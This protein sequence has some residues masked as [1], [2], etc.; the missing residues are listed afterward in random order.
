VFERSLP[1]V[2]PSAALSIKE[3]LDL[4]YHVGY[5]RL[6]PVTDMYLSRMHRYSMRGIVMLPV[7]HGPV[8]GMAGS[9][10]FWELH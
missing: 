5:S 9:R 2:L 6:P 3:K 10:F 1:K 4:D 8:R 7:P